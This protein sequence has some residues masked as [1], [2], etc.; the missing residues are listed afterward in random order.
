[1]EVFESGPHSFYNGF[2]FS[3]R[4]RFATHYQV[5]R[6]FAKA[7]DDVTDFTS[8]VPFN[9]IDEGKMAEYLTLPGLDR[10][11]SVN[12]QRHRVITNFVWNFG[13]YASQTL[14]NRILQVS[15]KIV[16]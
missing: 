3:F 1:V 5:N 4:R 9:S 8:V 7:I 2:T 6:T 15:G 12:D 14:D 11:P 13:T 16:F 10:G